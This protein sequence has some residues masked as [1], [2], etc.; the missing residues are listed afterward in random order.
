MDPLFGDGAKVALDTS[1]ANIDLQSRLQ[2]RTLRKASRNAVQDSPVAKAL[3]RR[4]TDSVVDT[5]LIYKLSP[6]YK[7]LNQDP[8]RY[9]DKINQY[10]NRFALWSKSKKCSLNGV[11]N[12]YQ[13]QRFI[14]QSWQRDGE[15]FLR[16]HYK[17]ED[18]RLL[19]P[20]R[21]EPIESDNV[22][23][24]FDEYN[25]YP[26][27]KTIVDGIEYNIDGEEAAYY[28]NIITIKGN[29]RV[30]VPA[31]DEKSGMPLMIHYFSPEYVLQK[32]GL[33]PISS[34]LHE[35]E[36]LKTFTHAQL[37]S[38]IIQ[39]SISLYQEPSDTQDGLP[40]LELSANA[41]FAGSEG[42]TDTERNNILSEEMDSGS[43]PDLEYSSIGGVNLIPGAMGVFGSQAGTKLRAFEPKTPVPQFESFYKSMIS[44]LSASQGWPYE[45]LAMQFNANYSASRAS[46]LMA[47]RAALVLLQ[48]LESDVLDVIKEAW[49]TIEIAKRRVEMPGFSD[50]IL[51]QAW[52]SG[53]WYGPP[54]MEID[55][56]HSVQAIE[57]SVQLGLTTLSRAAQEQNGS[58]YDD[59]VL[60]LADEFDRLPQFPGIENNKTAEVSGDEKV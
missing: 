56:L 10:N 60:Q 47:Y 36:Q 18:N 1:Y 42:L 3:V 30:R 59:N 2:F 26:K 29:K 25:K 23:G 13:L 33:P 5:G 17:T 28:I 58:N 35:C 32:R 43:V 4:A 39:A 7:T 50:P 53:K 46:I 57:K 45:Y 41:Q 55:Q 14:M 44:I 52:L 48:E 24:S 16:I 49:F 27:D 51:K 15:G 40:P 21:I 54:L 6:D 19:S 8:N 11:F 20:L 38:A 22:D 31:Y 34:M 37:M 9:I 12:F